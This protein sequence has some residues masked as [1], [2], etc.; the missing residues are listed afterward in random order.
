MWP[1]LLGSL[2]VELVFPA[3]FL[4]KQTRKIN[5]MPRE[6]WRADGV[7]KK[8]LGHFKCSL[9]EGQRE[10]GDFTARGASTMGCL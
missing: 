7:W 6:A 8:V 3:W 9:V 2:E 4:S 5:K 1:K 10:Q